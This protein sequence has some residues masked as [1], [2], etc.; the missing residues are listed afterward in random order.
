[1]ALSYE[2]IVDA[3]G[4]ILEPPDLWER[5]MDPPLRDR[6]LRLILDEERDV[7]E[8]GGRPSRFLTVSGLNMIFGGMGR[9]DEGLRELLTHNYLA[10]AP[11]GSTDPKERVELLDREGLAKAILYPSLGITWECELEDPEL[12]MAYA[13]AYNRW[14]CEF[15]SDSDG[16]LVVEFP[17][18]IHQL[19]RSWE[20]SI[21]VL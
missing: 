10:G 17:N 7:V 13:R 18:V 14:I 2:N 12:H 4:H 1:M 8:I 11:F 5:Y 21:R 16:R 15:C 3:D 19:R 9:N 20:G 6:A